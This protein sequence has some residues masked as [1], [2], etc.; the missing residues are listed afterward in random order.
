VSN[1]EPG[2]ISTAWLSVW[3]S[4]A[5]LPASP[6]KPIR[7]SSV[8]GQRKILCSAAGP[9]PHVVAGMDGNRTHLGRLS[10]APQTVLKTAGASTYTSQQPEPDGAAADSTGGGEPPAGGAGV[11]PLAGG[12]SGDRTPQPRIVRRPSLTAV[13]YQCSEPGCCQNC[14]QADMPA[15]G[16]PQ[17]FV[18]ERTYDHHMWWWTR[19]DSNP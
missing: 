3:L 6:P 19:G 1:L 13:T 2:R 8:A 18:Y 12:R 10:T 16:P 5:S 17:E 11:S 7:V 4:N 15:I 14:C 9:V